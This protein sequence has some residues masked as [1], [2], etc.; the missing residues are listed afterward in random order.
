MK[1]FEGENYYRILQVPA[2]ATAVEIRR[3]YRDAL[4]IYEEGSIATY[5][6]FSAEQRNILLQAIEKAF[7]T[8]INEESRAA[9]NKTLIDTGQVEASFFSRQDQR[10][11]AA[12]SDTQSITKEK[13]L[14]QWVKNKANTPEIKKLIEEILSREVLSGRDLKQLR[15]AFGIEFSEIYAITKISATVLNMI[16][17][18]EF[19][20]LPAEI[21]LKQFLKAYAE[22]LQIDSRQV[23][24]GYLKGMVQGKPDH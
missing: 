7:D 24:S 13:S 2:D 9:Y 14:S 8:L 1:T 10:K 23:V 22:I 5:S 20:G 15:E 18:D 19:D 21:Y 12:Y 11:L 17:A 4:A 6:L 3:A 16:E